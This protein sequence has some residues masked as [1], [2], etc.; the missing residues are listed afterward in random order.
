MEYKK[1]KSKKGRCSTAGAEVPI[2]VVGDSR[3]TC[4]QI[5]RAWLTCPRA[6]KRKD[7]VWKKIRQEA[8]PLGTASPLDC[9]I[10]T[11]GSHGELLLAA[12]SATISGN[13]STLGAWQF[14]FDNLV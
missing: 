12:Q 6:G 9:L 14:I 1:R 2:S 4:F 7:G 11:K 5:V 13:E 10:A 8:C 3:G